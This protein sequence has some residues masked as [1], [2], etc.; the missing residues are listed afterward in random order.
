MNSRISVLIGM[1][2]FFASGIALM[3]QALS[4]VH[5]FAN[6]SWTEAAFF[7]G[8]ILFLASAYGVAN[9]QIKSLNALGKHNFYVKQVDKTFKLVNAKN[10]RERL[11]AATTFTLA[12]EEAAKL[13]EDNPDVLGVS[14]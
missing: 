14:K 5:L 3:V 11:L 13:V 8:L 4:G 10:E 2:V 9:T 1:V 7:V 12:V 6:L